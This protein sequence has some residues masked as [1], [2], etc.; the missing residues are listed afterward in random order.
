M[1]RSRH[2]ARKATGGKAPPRKKT[3]NDDQNSSDHGSLS[4]NNTYNVNEDN[5]SKSFLI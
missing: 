5:E 3:F 1:A 4:D 2:T